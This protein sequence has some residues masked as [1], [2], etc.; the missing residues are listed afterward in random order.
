MQQGQ[1]S[2]N[3][4]RIGGGLPALL[5]LENVDQSLSRSKVRAKSRSAVNQPQSE[6]LPRS[7]IIFLSFRYHG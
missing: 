6:I 7:I 2:V 4:R 1:I 5:P 3:E